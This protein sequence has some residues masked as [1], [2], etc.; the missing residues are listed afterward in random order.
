MTVMLRMPGGERGI[1]RYPPF[2]DSVSNT[3]DLN[4]LTEHLMKLLSVFQYIML[5]N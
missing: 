3:Y 2:S 4:L 5:V 1:W